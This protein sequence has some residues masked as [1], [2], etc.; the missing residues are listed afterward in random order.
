MALTVDFN[1]TNKVITTPEIDLEAS[2]A[3]VAD[4]TTII[5]DVISFI[6]DPIIAP[7]II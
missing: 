1:R 5:Y 3:I 7:R 4:K 2:L 6:R